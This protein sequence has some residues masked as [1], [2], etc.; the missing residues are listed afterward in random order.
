MRKEINHNTSRIVFSRWSRKTYSV[1]ASLGKEVTIGQVVVDIANCSYEKGC[2]KAMTGKKI[3]VDDSD[4]EDN[5]GSFSLFS[6]LEILFSNMMET[7]VST[8]AAF[9]YYKDE[10]HILALNDISTCKGRIPIQ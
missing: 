1:F 2:F 7:L 9:A 4:D 6:E 5:T 10:N 8:F 3:M